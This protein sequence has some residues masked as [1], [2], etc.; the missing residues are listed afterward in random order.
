MLLLVP[1]TATGRVAPEPG[2][3]AQMAVGRPVKRQARK[4]P[5]TPKGNPASKMDSYL[6]HVNDL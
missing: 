1:S 2:R 6:D 3:R 5:G 4:K